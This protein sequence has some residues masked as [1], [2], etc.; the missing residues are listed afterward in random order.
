MSKVL[1]NEKMKA[2]LVKLIQLS[3]KEK[4]AYSKIEGALNNLITLINHGIEDDSVKEMIEKLQRALEIIL[5]LEK[6][7]EKDEKFAEK[8]ALKSQRLKEL[9]GKIREI[10]EI[11]KSLEEKYKIDE[12]EIKEIKQLEVSLRNIEKVEDEE[13]KRKLIQVVAFLSKKLE[14]LIKKES[15]EVRNLNRYI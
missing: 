12:E 2:A 6:I 13:K 11:V 1:D 4:E 14:Q 15:E 9:E 7:E 5:N 8:L 10:E 3:E